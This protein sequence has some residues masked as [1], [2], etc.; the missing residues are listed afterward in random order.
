MVITNLRSQPGEPDHARQL[1]E[2]G[3]AFEQLNGLLEFSRTLGAERD[4]R[5]LLSSVCQWAQQ[6][7]GAR[8]CFA[9]VLDIG[10][11]HWHQ[12]V[13][14]GL[15]PATAGRLEAIEPRRGPLAAV[16]TQGRCCR[17]RNPDGD[18]AALGLPPALAPVYSVLA[19]PVASPAE[20]Y[21]WLGLIDKRDAEEFSAQD[22]RL[23]ALL[24]AQLAWTYERDSLYADLLRY[25][26]DLER[27]GSE[28][29]H[30]EG[31]LQR[32]QKLAAI[33]RLAGGVAHDFN[34]L[35]TVMNGYGELVQDRLPA[36]DPLRALVVEILAAGSRAAGL[37]SQLLAFSRKA[38]LEPRVLDLKEL[39]S[40]LHP[41]LRR[42]LGEPIHLV[43]LSDP[44]LGGVLADPG[45]IEQVLVNLAVNAR[46]AM[47][48]GGRLTLEM[49]NVRL[50]EKSSQHFS[51]LRPGPYVLLAVCDT[52]R[53]M[54]PATL[55]RLFEPFFT[56]KG[57]KGAGLGL[58]TVH[59][60]VKQSGG[61]VAVA[62][63][64]GCGTTVK[65]FLPRVQR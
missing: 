58:A 49:R 48:H 61:Q 19:V 14:C 25:A 11:R 18:P 63:E 37:S 56:T 21:G 42:L 4:Q 55:A 3:R 47:P 15:E 32:A 27:E 38:G 16:L 10:G 7:L 65:V 17:L 1:D 44:V 50:S 20:V 26:A 64:L 36:D 41:M 13:S 52:G 12:W 46:D 24:A 43:T 33:G 60:I 23:A 39:L 8:C 29:K 40:N 62:S 51:D 22:E 5:Q 35:L 57:E 30:L 54:D 59:S 31:Q 53:G 28:R 9:G 45:Q 34:N 6:L 2:L